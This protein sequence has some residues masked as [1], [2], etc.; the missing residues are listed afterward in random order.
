MSTDHVQHPP[1]PVAQP[2]PAVPRRS[3]STR[4][5][6]IIALVLSVVALVVP[7][8]L[9]I[10]PLLAF[11]A[12]TSDESFELGPGGDPDLLGPG[13]QGSASGLDVPVEDGTVRGSALARS[14]RDG[15]F[16]D[17]ALSCADA[18]PA[19]EGTSVLCQTPGESPTYVVVRFTDADGGYTA[20]W[21]T[22]G[23][24]FLGF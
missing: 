11:G 7:A 16:I 2:P 21:F 18:A 13:P 10:L 3:D 19:R 9:A 24:D 4:T 14:L 17:E 6:A 20:H 15:P 23:E 8:G 12:F 22:P 5:I 1:G